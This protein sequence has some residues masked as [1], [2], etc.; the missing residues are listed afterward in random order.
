[1]CTSSLLRR[2]WLADFVD[3]RASPRFEQG[4]KKGPGLLATTARSPQPVRSIFSFDVPTRKFR[5]RV[6]QKFKVFG[7]IGYLTVLVAYA[8]LQHKDVV[9]VRP[10][11]VV[12]IRAG[13]GN[14]RLAA[15]RSKWPLAEPIR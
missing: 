8:S 7:H 4:T 3:L 15:L 10:G 5:L 6:R 11:K 12:L 1:M 14:T 13:R 9:S 2:P